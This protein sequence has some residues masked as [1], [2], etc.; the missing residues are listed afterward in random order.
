MRV[1]IA[2]VLPHP[3]RDRVGGESQA[4]GDLALLYFRRNRTD[5][6]GIFV[7]CVGNFC[8]HTEAKVVCVT[9]RH[10]EFDFERTQIDDR[11]ECCV[12]LVIVVRSATITVPID[13]V[14]R[15]F[16]LQ[17]C[18]ASLQVFDD[19]SLSVVLETLAGAQLEFETFLCNCWPSGSRACD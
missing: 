17:I 8:I 3:F 1:D 14:D 10:L 18:D 4:P 9:F 11:Q 6:C 16:D 15:R 7:C 2:L 13:A 5:R 12:L 19:Q